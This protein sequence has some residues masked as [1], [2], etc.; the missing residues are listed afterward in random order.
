MDQEP[1][2]SRRLPSPP[3]ELLKRTRP[4]SS[5]RT[6]EVLALE[7]EGNGAKERQEIRAGEVDNPG[8]HSPPNHERNL[9]SHPSDP[10]Y[11]S[12]PWKRSQTS[13]SR[14]S[15]LRGRRRGCESKRSRSWPVPLYLAE[16][17]RPSRRRSSSIK[18]VAADV[19]MYQPLS[20]PCIGYKVYFDTSEASDELR[21]VCFFGTASVL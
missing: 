17:R 20:R 6:R 9:L 11:R 3:R 12:S 15:I 16:D 4:G 18:D 10:P 7:K 1:T 13:L 21:R 8:R 14:R 2:T 19:N 5:C